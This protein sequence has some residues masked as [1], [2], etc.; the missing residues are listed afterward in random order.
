VAYLVVHAQAAGKRLDI[1]RL[2]CRDVLT[3]D[4][5]VLVGPFWDSGL[6]HATCGDTHRSPGITLASAIPPVTRK[7]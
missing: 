6:E 4:K 3:G 5:R 1:P 7:A 2:R